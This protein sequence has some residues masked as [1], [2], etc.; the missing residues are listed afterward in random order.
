MK[1]LIKRIQSDIKFIKKDLK[2]DEKDVKIIKQIIE[3]KE[4]R[5]ADYEEILTILK[6]EINEITKT[7]RK[8]A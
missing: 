6:F 4:Q 2:E 3:C 5:I 7:N 1:E 8:E